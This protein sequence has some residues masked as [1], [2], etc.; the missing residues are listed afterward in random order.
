MRLADAAAGEQLPVD[1]RHARLAVVAAQR[2]ECADQRAHRCP[3]SASTDSAPV[4]T[5]PANT[6]FELE[7]PRER[8]CG[9]DLRAV[10][11]R[12][13][14]LRSQRQGGDALLRE[15]L[16]GAEHFALAADVPEP[17][18]GAATGAPAGARSPEAPT[19]PC[20][21]T[22]G[23]EAGVDE[24][25]EEAGELGAD[26]RETLH[27]ACELEHQREAHDGII[28]QRPDAG[29][30]REDDVALQEAALRRRDA[31][32]REQSEAGVDPVGRGLARRPAAWSP[33]VP[34]DRA[35]A[36]T[37]RWRPL[38]GLRKCAA[39]RRVAARGSRASVCQSRPSQYF[40]CAHHG[41][42]RVETN[43]VA[44]LIRRRRTFQ[45]T[46]SAAWP[47]AEACRAHPRARGRARRGA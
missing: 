41:P 47:A 31:G 29:A 23:H 36:K 37:D 19:E 10:Q 18:H 11:Q 17:Q 4:T 20:E 39:D 28:Q 46:K 7:Q 40:S 1:L 24:P 27:Q 34:R 43:P 45:T 16:G 25:L 33:R 38:P 8:E 26:A 13:P 12:E 3:C 5:A 15:G 2:D 32:L 21:G 9:G 35:H 44:Q 14:L 42:P 30:V 22:H 6:V